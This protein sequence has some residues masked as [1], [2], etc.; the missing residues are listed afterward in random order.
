MV[1]RHPVD[2][3]FERIGGDLRH[4]RLD[5]LPHARR[6][7]IDRERA[8]GFDD[9][10]RILARP[11]R[12]ALD[13]AGNTET[14]IAP[15]DQLAVQRKLVMPAGILDAVIEGAGIVAAVA[16]GVAEAIVGAHRRQRIR[17]LRQRD[18]V[19]PPDIETVEAEILRG[20]VEQPVH[21]E[22]ALKATGTTISP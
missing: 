20:H 16:R 6:S 9:N 2:R 14:V 7:H 4:D 10:A 22:A 8:V 18:E 1:D 13:E 21:E 5:A 11:G 19:A 17:H 15:V 12:A 3:H